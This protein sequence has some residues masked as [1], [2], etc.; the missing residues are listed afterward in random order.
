[1][2]RLKTI[3]WAGECVRIID[4]TQLPLTLAYADITTLEAM[5]EAI[6]TL[7]VRGAP[8]LGIAAAFGLYLGIRHFPDNSTKDEFIAEL[9]RKAEYLSESRPTAVNL[10][11]ALRRMQSRVLSSSFTTV[12]EMKMALLQEAREIYEEDKRMCRAIG[13]NGFELLQKCRTILTHCN[14]GGLATSEYGTALAP[15]YV[16]QEKGILIHVYVD[17]TRPLLQGARITAFELLAAGIP[18]TLI[19]DNMAAAVMALG[20]VEAVIVGADRIA[21]NGDAA[22]KIGT[23]GL[24]LLAKAH[25]IPLYVAAPSTTFDLSIT[26]GGKIPIEERPADEI[27][28][29][30]G[31]QTAPL[32]VDVFNPAFDVTP[33]SLI[34]AMVTEKGILRPPFG[35]AISRSFG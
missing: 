2:A 7:R 24:A 30:F 12:P 35:P 19:C 5:H 3:E 15:V 31:T 13:E 26:D 11:W 14:A 10:F 23:Y 27:V 32:T 16:A 8:A 29:G 21:A 18:V 1:M 28:R 34:S 25:G 20:R 22:N 17:E 4:Q 33:H 9:A 6:R